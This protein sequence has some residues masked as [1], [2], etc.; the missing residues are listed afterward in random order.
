MTHC[1]E[2]ATA[3]GVANGQ[4]GESVEGEDKRGKLTRRHTSGNMDFQGRTH[5]AR[6]RRTRIKKKSYH[7]SASSDS[8]SDGPAYKLR[9][10]SMDEEDFKLELE[11][12]D[13]NFLQDARSSKKRLR[14]SRRFIFFLG[15]LIGLLIPVYFGADHIHQYN[16]ELID[17]YLDMNQMRNYFDEWSSSLPPGVSNWMTDLPKKI[18]FSQSLEKELKHSFA[19]GKKFKNELNYT[20]KYPIVMVPGVIST[21]IEN[22]GLS[23]DDECDSTPHFRKRLWGSFYMLRTMVLDKICWLKHVKLDPITGLDP[24]N[25]TLRAAQGFESADYFI[26]G[27]WIWNKIIENLGAIGY[28]PNNMVTASYDWRLAYLDLEKRDRYFTKFK[29]QIELYH[30]L[31]GNKT[32]LVGHSMGSQI[33]FYFLQWVEAMGPDYGNGGSGWVNKYIES[34]VN[35]AGTLLGAPKAVP[36]MLSGEMKDTIDLNT[37]AMYGLE[38]FFSKKERLELFQTWGGIPSM[39][40]KG[41]ELIWGNNTFAPENQLNN[42]FCIKNLDEEHNY[43]NFIMINTNKD[44]ITTTSQ[45]D[46]NSMTTTGDNT[47]HALV[48]PKDSDRFLTMSDSIKLVIKNSPIWLQE[49]IKDQYSYG[50]ALNEKELA[51]NKKH[52][53]HWTNPLEVPLPNAPDMKIYCIYGVDNPTERAYKYQEGQ[54]PFSSLNMTIDY[55]DDTPVYFADGDGTVPIMTH[56]MCHK[57]GEGKSPYNPSGLQ[58]KTVEIKHQPDKFDIRGGGHSAEHVDILGSTELNEYILRIA[59]GHGDEISTKQWTSLAQ[60]V[61]NMPFPM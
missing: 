10:F 47:T 55:S 16:P 46:N 61:A 41:G 39:L 36:A 11:S 35:V 5:R 15:A 7:K 32:V 22:W 50:F 12:S 2:S 9:S 44:N 25:F 33:I 14:D 1:N 26:T 17:K 49:R 3:S 45:N 23:G 48:N 18:M 53:S 19:L 27:Y 42:T 40:P 60:C 43:G 13:L 37:F 54:D 31:T 29:Q 58:V 24:Q 20:A 38:K 59:T 52:H 6:R 56:A 21:G 51:D 30:D 4:A 57:W 34:F 8:E 28:E